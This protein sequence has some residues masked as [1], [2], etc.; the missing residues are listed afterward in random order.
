MRMAIAAAVLVAIV[1][2]APMAQSPDA[3]VRALVDG[4]KFKQAATFVQADQDRFVRELIALTEIPAPPFKEQAR[5]KVYLEMLRQVGLTDVEMDPEGN[6]MGI[7]RGT[8]PAGGPLLLVNAHLDT[9]FPEGTDVKVKRQGTRLMAP[10]VGDDTR[11]LALILAL[12]RTLDAATFTTPADI[13]FAGNVGE[14]G[15]GDLRGIKFLLKTGK[16]KDRIKQVIAIDGSESNGITR[17]GL[18][19]RRYRV[20]FKGPGGH[21]YGAFGLVNPAFAMGG[22]IAKIARLEVPTKPKTT[23]NVGVVRG[24]TSV[25]SIPAEVSMDVDMRSEA[26]AELNRLDQEFLAVVRQA[27]DEENRTRSTKEGR[28]EADPKIIGE[29]PCGETPLDAPIVQAA[30]SAIK[31]FGLSPVFSINSTDANIPMSL[32]IPAVTIGRG[33]PGGRAHS[34]DEWVDVDPA[35]NVRNVQVALATILAVAG[36]G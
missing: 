16:Y 27:V 33:G 13:L 35:A 36:G 18:G 12:V 6:V 7:R 2:A 11:G 34:P 29:R 17:G 31:A 23:F 10:G 30:A 9:V 19:S 1:V 8:G 26:C 14:E 20:T 24:G 3:R 4:P 21:S 22:A 32:G 25:N 28:V 15:E 5:A